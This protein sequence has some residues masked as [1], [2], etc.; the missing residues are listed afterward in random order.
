VKGFSTGSTYSFELSDIATEFVSEYALGSWKTRDHYAGQILRSWLPY[1]DGQGVSRADAI[2]PPMIRDFLIAEKERG[3]SP[4]SIAHRY[5]TIRVF[6]NWCVAQGYVEENPA[7]RVRRPQ[8][9][10]PMV[11]PFPRDEI[12]R[13]VEYSG[14]GPGH[15]PTRDRAIVI[16]LLDTGARA[17]ELLGMRYSCVDRTQRRVTLHGK[18]GK[19]RRV[20]L[21]VQAMKALTAWLRVRW[22]V[23]GNDHIWLTQRRTTLSLNSL[24]AML[25]NLGDRAGVEEC[26]P[27]RFR[28]TAATEHYLAHHD[29]LAV[30]SMLGHEKFDTTQRYLRRLGLD[31]AAEAKLTTPGDWLAL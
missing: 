21:G 18:G 31:Y 12:K 4:Q 17:S 30:R 5:A 11:N 2:T 24:E 23:P 20:P 13:L 22:E 6:L 14:N 25:A 26:R 27:H 8:T 3:L 9:P 29:L 16:I 15:T 1:F 10:K 7:L 19:D 28:H